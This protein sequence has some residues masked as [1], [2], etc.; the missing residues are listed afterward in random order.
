MALEHPVDATQD[1]LP[2][3]SA[4]AGADAGDAATESAE[5]VRDDDINALFAGLTGSNV[6]VTRIRSDI[7]Q[8]R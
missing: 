7:A 5:E 1:Y 2:I 4:D 3:G 8:R 6:R